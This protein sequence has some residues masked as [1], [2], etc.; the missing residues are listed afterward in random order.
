LTEQNSTARI[1]ILHGNDEVGI[2]ARI[3]SMIAAMGEPT[4]AGMNLSRLDGRTA[5]L[6]E[7]S[8][9][10]GVMPFLAPYRLAVISEPPRR[11]NDNK[12]SS[13][14]LERH[15]K[16]EAARTKLLNFFNSMPETGRVVLAVDDE[17]LKKGGWTVLSQS[18]WLVKWAGKSGGLAQIEACQQPDVKDMGKWI[19]EKARGMGGTFSRAAAAEL[20]THVDSRTRLAEMEIGKLLDYV[21]YA[22]PVEQEDVRRLVTYSGEV[23]TFEMIDAVAEGNAAKAVRLL[24]ILLE[25]DEPQAVFGMLNRQFR[26]LLAAREIREEGGRPKQILEQMGGE[27]FR[28]NHPFVAEKLYNQAGRYSLLRL[29]EIYRSLVDLSIAVRFNDGRTE[30]TTFITGLSTPAR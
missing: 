27:P 7:I 3:Q 24:N 5:T 29:E 14:F 11:D 4:I 15:T 19:I 13:N 16:N 20:V 9:A 8:T 25:K 10:A 22:R 1:I 23:D 28:V 30:L 17:P 12:P 18:H 21:N 2:A 6:E 26:L